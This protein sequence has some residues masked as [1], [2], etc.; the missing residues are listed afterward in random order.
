MINA[1]C[2]SFGCDKPAVIHGIRGEEWIP[3]SYCAEHG[4]DVDALSHEGPV[5]PVEAARARIT[6]TLAKAEAA[7][8]VFP[9]SSLSDLS[10]D[11]GV[12]VSTAFF[13]AAVSFLYVSCCVYDITRS[14][15]SPLNS[16]SVVQRSESMRSWMIMTW[17]L[18]HWR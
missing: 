18:Q 3:E 10:D 1:V 2:G 4:K 6:D 7:R 15:F 5:T 17:C 11:N 8:T 9:W 13:I 14:I 16:I 12:S